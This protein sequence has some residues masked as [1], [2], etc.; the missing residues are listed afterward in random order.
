MLHRPLLHSLCLPI[1]LIA[2]GGLSA[3][4]PL[5]GAPRQLVVYPTAIDLDG[6]R[7][8]ERIGVLG[9]YADGRRCDLSREAKFSGGAAK[10]ATVDVA[11]IVHATGDGE[12]TIT[13]QVGGLSATVSV[14]AHR[15][16]AE[17]PVDFVREVVPVLTK[18][19]CNQGACHGAAIGRGGFK[20]SLL[21]FDPAFDYKEIVQSAEG[22]RVVAVRSRAQHPAAEAGVCSW[23]TAAANG[24][25]SGSR[26]Y[27]IIQPLAGGRR[28]RTGRQDH[29]WSPPWKYGRRSASWS[30]ASSSS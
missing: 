25:R 11:G 1:V 19:G 26:D 22:R 4:E 3:A 6:P 2:V 24:F 12:T 8:E 9:E 20:L 30:P 14:K 29:R 15:G 5:T 18:A 7:A 23:S 13:V 27:E 16:G 17:V 10:V 21:G 28:P